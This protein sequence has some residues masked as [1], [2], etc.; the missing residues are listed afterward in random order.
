MVRRIRAMGVVVGVAVGDVGGVTL[1]RETACHRVEA[2]Q[3]A[4]RPRTSAEFFEPNPM[5]L[6]SAKRAAVVRA[7]LGM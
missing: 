5:Q 3:S 2:D 7:T 6:Q 4:P 1:P